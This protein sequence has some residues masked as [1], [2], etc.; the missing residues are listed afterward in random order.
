MSTPGEEAAVGLWTRLRITFGPSLAG[1]AGGA[2]LGLAALPALG[3]LCRN[4]AAT[5]DRYPSLERPW[6]AADLPVPGWLQV[7]ALL[8]GLVG[9][10][11]MG[12]V[13]VRL[14]APRDAWADLSAGLTTALAATLAAFVSCIGWPVILA[15]VV[16][17]SIADLTLLGDSAG[18]PAKDSLLVR[19]YPDLE[20]VEPERRGA[21][22]M[23]KVVSDQVTGSAH[24]AWVGMLLAALT[25]GALALSG[26][27]A[28][29]YLK[30]RGDSLRQAALPYLEITLPLTCALAL[31]AGTLLGPIW[32]ALLG[33]NP[34]AANPLPLAGLASLT[35]LMIVGVVRRWPW[36]LRLC[37]ALT[38]L[39]L[40]AAARP[41]A[42]PGLATFAAVALTAVLLA[43]YYFRQRGRV[44]MA[45]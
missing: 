25:A 33:S 34:F 19:S 7:V 17:P 8:V 1:L 15:L 22:F 16:V 20:E 39:K 21:V 27:L 13:A 2:L 45:G 3:P 24:A 30:R 35:V 44:A 6:L 10:V 5:Y 12:A 26:V 43:L 14:S 40:L 23:A 41:G 38:W 28:A 11:A 4:M 42:S 37:M 36:L 31:V 32:S 18:T 29:G 9:A